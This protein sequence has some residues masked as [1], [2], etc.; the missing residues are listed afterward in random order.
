MGSLGPLLSQTGHLIGRHT[1]AL[2]G[3]EVW[4]HALHSHYISFACSKIDGLTKSVWSVRV[5]YFDGFADALADVS[6]PHS[7]MP[8]HTTFEPTR[9]TG[10]ASNSRGVRVST[11]R[12]TLSK[13]CG[14]PR[15]LQKRLLGARSW[16]EARD[17]VF[18]KRA[19]IRN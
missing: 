4:L 12:S 17:S 19:W 11:G 9:C 8:L 16:G 7:S 15:E 10:A 13:A 6:P 3:Q 2:S 5:G 18:S 14:L 1:I